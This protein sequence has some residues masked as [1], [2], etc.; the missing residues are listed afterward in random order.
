VTVTENAPGGLSDTEIYALTVG[1]INDAPELTEIGDQSIDEDNSVLG[2]AV[3]FSDLDLTDDH[4]ITVV[5]S[6]TGVSIANL[7]GNTSGSTYDLVPDPDW[8]GS[9]EITVTVTDDGTGPL[10]DSETYTFTVNP[11]NDAPAYIGLSNNAVDEG[12][13]IGTVVGLLSSTDPDISDTH[14]YEFVFEGGDE[15][16]D[17]LFFT[18]DLD[19]V[20]VLAE[21]DYEQQNTFSLLVKSDDGN[22][23][24][25]T[26]QVPVIVN[27]VV[28]TFIDENESLSFK[29]YPVPAV[30]YLTVEVDNPE[31]AE[32][33]LEIY[34]NAG[35]LVHSEHTVHG[36]IIDLNKFSKGMY[37]LRIRGERVF[38][39]CKIIVGD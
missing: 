14:T 39:T 26:Q 21:L 23:G 12:V 33:L 22:G 25:L 2:L 35:V 16:I 10:S 27:N 36:N 34:S 8:N 31:N 18:I 24:T 15:E 5:S 19:T 20:K 3:D 1:A 30:D 11:I 28:E 38:E 7:I 4:T 29:V 17:N 32:L 6:E 9:T 37:I 13:A